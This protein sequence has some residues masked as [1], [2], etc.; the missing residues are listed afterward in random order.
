MSYPELYRK[1][2]LEYRNQ[3]YTLEETHKVFNVAVV[4]IYEWQRK[5][6]RQGRSSNKSSGSFK[7]SA[8]LRELRGNIIELEEK[9]TRNQKDRLYLI[10]RQ[11]EAI[12]STEIIKLMENLIKEIRDA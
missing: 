10:F 1:R 9:Q 12:N 8:K 11:A 6:K 4:T 3:G 2:V 7:N 5:L